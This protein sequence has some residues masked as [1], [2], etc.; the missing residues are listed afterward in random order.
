MYSR[1]SARKGGGWAERVRLCCAGHI[2][3]SG[4]RK[5]SIHGSISFCNLRVRGVGW[6][7]EFLIY[8]DGFNS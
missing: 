1:T 7:N 2:I 8:D 4:L 3:L 6:V 5:L